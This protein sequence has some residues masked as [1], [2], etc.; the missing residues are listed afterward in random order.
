MA[1]YATLARPYARAA[2]EYAHEEDALS[3]WQHFLDRLAEL[4][5]LAPVRDLIAS[6]EVGRDERATFIGELAGERLPKGGANL[7]RL[8]AE[9]GRLEVLP[10]VAAE[11][12]R[13]A[14]EAETTVKVAIETA[15]PLAKKSAERLSE[16]LGK[17]LGR[18]VEASFEVVP[19][20]IGG[21]VMRIGDHV[22]DASLATRLRRLAT[23][24]AG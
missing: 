17:R 18:K 6:P 15:V 19:A 8:M 11:F 12:G 20:I 16:A 24:M 23:A 7:L 14:A 22:V 3:R 13:L 1:D 9:N 5:A 4:V 21:V 2:F 10:A